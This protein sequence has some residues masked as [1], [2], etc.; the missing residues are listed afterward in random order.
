MMKYL[1]LMGASKYDTLLTLNPSKILQFNMCQ[2][3]FQ[4]EWEI[5]QLNEREQVTLPT[6]IVTED[7]QEQIF[8]KIEHKN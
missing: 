6:D 8:L 7:V 5:V 2:V 1:N 3:T 4:V